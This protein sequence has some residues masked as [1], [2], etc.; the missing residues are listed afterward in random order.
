MRVMRDTIQA[1]SVNKSFISSVT[2]S[3][4]V[5]TVAVFE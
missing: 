5:F 1:T 2:I 3:E 4:F